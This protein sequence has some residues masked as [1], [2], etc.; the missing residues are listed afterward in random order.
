[1]YRSRSTKA[2][3]Q[4]IAVLVIS[5]SSA[6]A[7]QELVAKI[8]SIF[9][10][11][12]HTD[13]PG[14]A[15]GVMRNGAVV[16]RKGYGMANLEHGIP[17]TASTVFDVASVAK[18][19]CAFAVLQLMEAEKVSPSAS[20]RDYLPELHPEMGS[21]KV[22]HLVHHTS[23]LRDWPGMLALAGYRMEDV[24]TFDDIMQMAYAQRS[25]NYEPGSEYSYSNTGYNLL[26]AI[27]NK[28]SGTT[29]RA[30]TDSVIFR[31]LQMTQTVFQDDHEIVL[32]GRATAYAHAGDNFQRVGNTLSAVGSSSLFSSV[33]DLLRWAKSREAS[34]LDSKMKAKGDLNSG[35][36]IGYAFGQVIGTFRG[37]ETVSHSGSWAGFRSAL[38]RF[39]G[40]RFAVIILA[41][42]SAISPMDLALDIS[43]LYLGDAMAPRPPPPPPYSP[44]HDQL[45]QY[46]GVYDLGG[47]QIVR[48]QKVGNELTANG[49]HLTMVGPDEFEGG[50]RHTFNRGPNG[51]IISLQLGEHVGQRHQRYIPSESELL[52]QRGIYYNDA[53]ESE[54]HLELN[55]ERVTLR[56]ARRD[57]IV[58]T[59]AIKNVHT[60]ETW[61]MPVVR[62]TRDESQVV[63][64]LSIS[65][66]RS[67]HI[68]FERLH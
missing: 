50:D 43:E 42:T 57:P 10:K 3:L 8:D 67:R 56:I 5:V 48:V 7:Q 61:F 9:A 55:D 18:Q 21:I 63:T 51:T 37:L 58:L 22:K 49:A 46:S 32:P 28:Q 26:A 66:N 24:I 34:P 19:F 6:Q 30:Y 47:A 27:V 44:S 54:V 12:D 40:E 53:L 35:K 16:L 65:N 1:M 68:Q 25:L 59:P 41:N 4:F 64:G 31:P 36:T 14:A 11:W 17:N 29:F 15:I 20:I 23:G 62:L 13:T 39:P 38:L 52:S 45:D 33:N 60:T 2:C